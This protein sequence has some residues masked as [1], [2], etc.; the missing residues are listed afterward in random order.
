MKINQLDI[1]IDPREKDLGGF[2]VRRVPP[3]AAH[4][5]VCNAG[6]HFR[7]NTKMSNQALRTMYGVFVKS[8]VTTSKLGLWPSSKKGTIFF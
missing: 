1:V 3:F 6:S 8:M 5:M 4:R 7:N 2:S